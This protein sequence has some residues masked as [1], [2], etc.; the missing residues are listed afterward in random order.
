M[1]VEIRTSPDELSID[2]E[3][4][5][6]KMLVSFLLPIDAVANITLG[7]PVTITVPEGVAR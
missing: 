5:P 6:G 4:Y 1:S 3:L 7:T 2:P